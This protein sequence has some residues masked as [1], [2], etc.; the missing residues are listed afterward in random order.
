M[1]KFVLERKWGFPDFRLLLKVK[2][3]AEP[4][5]F[6]NLS[7]LLQPA[8]ASPGSSLPATDLT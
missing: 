2:T 6:S 5:Q 7:L 4:P 8:P 1:W 3:L